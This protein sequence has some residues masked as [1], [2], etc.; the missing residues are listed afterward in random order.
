MLNCNNE[1]FDD[2]KKQN[3]ENQTRFFLATIFRQNQTSPTTISNAPENFASSTCAGIT[4]TNT[5]T[6]GNSVYT[7]GYRQVSSINQD[8]F[9]KKVTSGLEDWNKSDYDTSPDDSRGEALFANS[10]NLFVA[11]SAT[12]GNTGLRN[13]VSSDA[14][15]RS[16]GNG[17]GPKV[18]FLARIDPSNGNIIRGTFLAARLDNGRVNTLKPCSVS[19]TGS[20]EITFIGETAYDGGVASDSLTQGQVCAS[21]SKR[22]IRLNFN[23]NSK[24]S[25]TC[26]PN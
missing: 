14:V 13:F 26:E 16:Y 21:G 7:V 15:Q 22:T 4:T 9:V 6:S 10:G 11:F 12:G 3:Q 8:A 20:D 24:I 25:V 23:L 17:G 2:G 5:S 18:T 19:V 1:I